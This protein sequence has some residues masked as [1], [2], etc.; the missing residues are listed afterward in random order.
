MTKRERVLRAVAFDEVDRV[1]V[2]DILQ[3]DAIIEHYS[4]MRIRPGNGA[5]ITALAVGRALNPTRMAGGPIE[6]PR[7]CAKLAALLA[8]AR[9]FRGSPSDPSMTRRP[10]RVDP[11]GHRA[12]GCRGLPRGAPARLPRYPRRADGPFR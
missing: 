9:W 8:V 5:R 1:P 11:R 6:K 10:R 4:G 3:N 7:R 2:Y 12:R